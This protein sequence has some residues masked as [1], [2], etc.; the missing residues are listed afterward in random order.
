[1]N[2]Y[3]TLKAAFKKASTEVLNENIYK[4]IERKIDSFFGE[5]HSNNILSLSDLIAVIK[6]KFRDVF[7]E[8]VLEYNLEH[9]LN[10]LNNEIKQNRHS[11]RDIKDKDY[12]RE[13]FDSYVVDEKENITNMLDDEIKVIQ[14][15]CNNIEMQIKQVSEKINALSQENLQFENEYSDLIKLQ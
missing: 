7:K 14:D 4:T 2:R 13:I 10:N 9:L 3:E 5:T 8:K 15:Q 11:I 6:S 12:I 1:M